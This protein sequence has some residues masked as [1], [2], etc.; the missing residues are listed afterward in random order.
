[1][2]AGAEQNWFVT[3][4]RGGSE[5]A[6]RREPGAQ[7]Q[8]AAF[9]LHPNE[10]NPFDGVTTIR[11]DLPRASHVQLEVFDL[12][13]RRVATLA[14]RAYPAGYHAVQW[15]HFF[16]QQRLSPGVY[17]YRIMAG[18]RRAQRKMMLVQ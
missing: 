13:G 7:E 17:M 15:N 10:P 2:D 9:A 4:R 11:F 12:L 8:P 16:A 6:S 18:E 1:M 14:D 5:S 3:V